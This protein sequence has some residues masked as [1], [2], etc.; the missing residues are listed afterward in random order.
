VFLFVHMCLY[1]CISDPHVST[2]HMCSYVFICVYMCVSLIHMSYTEALIQGGVETL[3]LQVIFCKIALKL[4]ALLQ[5]G[6]CNRTC[7]ILI[8]LIQC[9][10]W[11]GYD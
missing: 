2:I 9:A 11:G 8:Y 4:V 1:V 5:K 3:S 6:T 10:I 7:V